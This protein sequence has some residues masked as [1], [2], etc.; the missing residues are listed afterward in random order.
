MNVSYFW[1]AWYDL[2]ASERALNTENLPEFLATVEF[3]RDKA[4]QHYARRDH[5]K[6][7]PLLDAN[8]TWKLPTTLELPPIDFAP[9]PLSDRELGWLAEY[10]THEMP[11]FQAGQD[12]GVA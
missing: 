11:S 1:A 9:P 5:A 4:E 12:A 10:R 2:G 7:T 6:A 8:K 3:L